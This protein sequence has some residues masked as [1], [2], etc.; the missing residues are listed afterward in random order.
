MAELAAS[1]RI[2]DRRP[3][4]DGAGLTLV[5]DIIT[6]VGHSSWRGA[7]VAMGIGTA[8]RRTAHVYRAATGTIMVGRLGDRNICQRTRG[9]A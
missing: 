4:A 6:L 9:R 7:K 5:L 8:Y 1:Q 3:M 2:N